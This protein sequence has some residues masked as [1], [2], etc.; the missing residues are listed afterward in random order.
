ML[1][2]Q[3]LA[4]QAQDKHLIAGVP[5][6]LVLQLAINASML[7]IYQESMEVNIFET[8]VIPN[9]EEDEDDGD[10]SIWGTPRS[11]PESCY[12]DAE[13]EIQHDE[14][15]T[16]PKELT[17]LPH[18]IPDDPE[19]MMLNLKDELLRWC[20]HLGHASFD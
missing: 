8:H 17:D 13:Q 18:V 5:E 2:P 15:N 1:S 19:P 16:A 6:N 12:V 10:T 20:Y 3:H 7:S 4:K 11:E 14:F 9:V